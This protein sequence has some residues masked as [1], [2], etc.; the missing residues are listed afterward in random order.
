MG[1]K[2]EETNLLNRRKRMIEMKPCQIDVSLGKK[3]G[4]NG[5]RTHQDKNDLTEREYEECESDESPLFEQCLV[6]RQTG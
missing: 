6:E 5:E 2:K 3:R 4:H 1:H